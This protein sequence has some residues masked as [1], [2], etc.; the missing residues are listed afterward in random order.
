MTLLYAITPALLSQQ[1]EA[2]S[3]INQPCAS[4]AFDVASI[5]PSGPQT[6]MAMGRPS[7]L[8][9]VNE[10]GSTV[11]DLIREAYQLRPFQIAG[12]PGWASTDRFDVVAKSEPDQTKV[13]TISSARAFAW[14]RSAKVPTLT[15]IRPGRAHGH[16]R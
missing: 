12:L 9:D 3:Q 2:P 14:K 16:A 11:L 10:A 5:R 15:E 4:G 6:R 7:G 13:G 1:T 8:S